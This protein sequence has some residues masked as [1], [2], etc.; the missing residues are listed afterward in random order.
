MNKNVDGANLQFIVDRKNLRQSKFVETELPTELSGGKLIVKVERFAF[1]ANNI[2]YAVLGE[3]LRYW[4]HFPASGGDGII[5]VC[6]LGQVLESTHPGIRVGERLYGY[7]PMARYVVIEPADIEDRRFRDAAPHRQSAAA[8]YNVYIRITGDSSFEGRLGDFQA[9]VRPLIKT[10]FLAATFFAES[11]FFGAKQVV[12][13][14]ASS[15]TSL[16]LAYLL[17]NNHREVRVVGLTSLKNV[18]FLKSTGLYDSIVTYDKIPSLTKEDAAIFFDVAGNANVRL[19]IHR[20]FGDMLKHSAM[21]GFAHWDS[22]PSN[23]ALPGPKHELFFGPSHI[24]RLH[25]KWGVSE[26][27]RRFEAVAPGFIE[28]LDRWI[29]LV[30]SQSREDVQSIYLKYVEGTAPADIGY[31]FS[32][33]V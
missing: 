31:I 21:V 26:F 27:D 12:L 8:T 16:G 20:H 2:L 17:H 23:E 15:K 19:E 30:G 32:L 13:S 25:E 10:A 7:F 28:A 22:P 6:G 18:E 29:H 24:T 5:P 1:T 4:D 11:K 3:R 33:H 14:S 9:L